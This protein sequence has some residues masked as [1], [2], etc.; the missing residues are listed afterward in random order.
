[1]K[2]V[3]LT[4]SLVI[5]LCS[6]SLIPSDP[7]QT[8]QPSCRATLTVS[9]AATVSMAKRTVPESSCKEGSHQDIEVARS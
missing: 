9:I 6:A 4:P 3:K 2:R 1:M 7:T 5:L 8:E